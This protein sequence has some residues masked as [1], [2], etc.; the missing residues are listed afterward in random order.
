MPAHGVGPVKWEMQRDND[1]YRDYKVTYLI[2][3][4]SSQEGPAQVLECPDLPQPGYQYICQ[5]DADPWAWCKL[6]TKITQMTS[7]E[8]GY[9]WEAEVLFSTKPDGKR[10]KD[11]QIDD[12]LMVPDRISGGFTKYQEE[13]TQDLFGNPITNSAWE[14][15]HGPQNEWD[16]GRPSVKIAMNRAQLQLALLSQMQDTVNGAPLWGLP[17]R[18]IKLSNTSWEK[19]YYGSCFPYYEISLEFDIRFETFDRD[20]LDEGT[21]VLHGHWDGKNKGTWIIDNIG[22][23]YYTGTPPNPANPQHYDRFTDRQGNQ[24]NVILNGHG[25]PAGVQVGTGTSSAKNSGGPGYRHVAKYD[26]SNFLL[27][28]IP[29]SF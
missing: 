21:K 23:N 22:G 17:P 5:A 15:F 26:G 11:Q 1:G 9:W 12:P 28:G 16:K 4:D 2:R 14:L 8:P 20:L 6:D 19:K 18:C 10:C 3:C 24:A 29:T 27:L 25:L 7:R 13:A